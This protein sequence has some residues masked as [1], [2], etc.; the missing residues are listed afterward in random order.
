MTSS[1]PVSAVVDTN[2][3]VSGLLGKKGP[4][5]ALLEAWYHGA[6][7]LLVSPVLREEYARVLPSPK[8]Q[9]TYGL[10]PEEVADLLTLI[11]LRSVEVT[12]TAHLPV[13]IRDPKD[14]MVLAAALGGAADYLVT[15]DED[16][17][18]LAGDPRLG[19]LK[20]VSVRAFLDLLEGS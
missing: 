8:F 13:A 19:T 3:L 20:I 5:H 11:A 4:P 15:G 10:T 2:L 9:R 14:T 12:P 18:V 7:N 17:L 1:A 16:L 6:F